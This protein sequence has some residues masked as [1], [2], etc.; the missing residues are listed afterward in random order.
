MAK[1]HRCCRLHTCLGVAQKYTLPSWV[2]QKPQSPPGYCTRTTAC[3]QLTHTQLGGDLLV[4]A[5]AAPD[6]DLFQF[7]FEATAAQWATCLC[8][9]SRSPS[10]CATWHS[11][12]PQ[13]SDGLLPILMF[14]IS[15]IFIFKD[16]K[17]VYQL[18]DFTASPDMFKQTST[19]QKHQAA[20]H[21]WI[22][23]EHWATVF[24]LL[25]YPPISKRKSVYLPCSQNTAIGRESTAEPIV[26]RCNLYRIVFINP[27]EP[28]HSEGEGQ[29]RES[30]EFCHCACT[31][32][33]R[34][35][36]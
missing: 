26:Q 9:R 28:H 34:S 24:Y 18:I 30:A 16:K 11:N 21:N 4:P 5:P 10:S 15:H 33:R 36:A 3:A 29:H 12:C 23:S 27:P 32:Q 14:W 17:W 7:L 13:L 6:P 19:N 22:F 31:G 2:L 8:S 1:R 25:C 20:S 35:T